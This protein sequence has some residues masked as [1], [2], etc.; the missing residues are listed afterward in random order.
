MSGAKPTLSRPQKGSTETI[1]AKHLTADQIAYVK[2]DAVKEHP[3][4]V[5]YRYKRVGE[6]MPSGDHGRD[7]F[8]CG[9]EY[10]VGGPD[11]KGAKV[12]TTDDQIKMTDQ[13]HD[14]PGQ[15]NSGPYI[16]GSRLGVG[17]GE[18]ESHYSRPGR[19]SG[20]TNAGEKDVNTPP[21]V[22]VSDAR[23]MGVGRHEEKDSRHGE[24][25]HDKVRLNGG[26][27]PE[28]VDT[29]DYSRNRSEMVPQNED[30]GSISSTGSLARRPNT[31][32]Q[33]NISSFSGRKY[34]S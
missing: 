20:T 17:N 24:A 10:Y 18:D 4:K 7:V 26:F 21:S 5:P 32:C 8:Q 2:K 30:A 31:R 25:T 28:A 29:S 15:P 6:G 19:R 13:R 12:G 3:E 22:T 9:N 11:M 16:G 27:K 1:P 34:K 33:E 23:E 14:R